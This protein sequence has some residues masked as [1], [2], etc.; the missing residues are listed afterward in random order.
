MSK[1]HWAVEVLLVSIVAILPS[2]VGSLIAFARPDS[3]RR[4]L[5]AIG[6]LQISVFRFM[7]SLSG[8]A[9]VTLVALHQPEG[10]ASVGLRIGR[11][12]LVADAALTSLLIVVSISAA[13]LI[14]ASLL[15]KRRP[16]KDEALSDAPLEITSQKSLL[17]RLL[18]ATVMPLSAIA[19]EMTYRGYLVLLCVGRTGSLAP[20]VL[21]SVGLTVTVHLYQGLQARRFIFHATFAGLM[22]WLTLYTGGIEGPILIHALLNTVTFGRAWR[23]VDRAEVGRGAEAS[24]VE[25]PRSGLERWGYISFIGLNVLL[26]TGLCCSLVLAF[27]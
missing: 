1:L 6:P 16:A 9:A 27:H 23:Q 10:L 13:A 12:D 21:L 2:V 5:E 26:L 15:R 11:G 18:F 14:M 19:E 7:Q 4:R 17:D 25:L 8:I 20:W 24:A 22:I 3:N